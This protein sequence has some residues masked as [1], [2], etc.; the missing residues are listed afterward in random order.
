MFLTIVLSFSKSREKSICHIKSVPLT[1]RLILIVNRFF[2]PTFHHKGCAQA[3]MLGSLGLASGWHCST[4]INP[5]VVGVQ[6]GN[7]QRRSVQFVFVKIFMQFHAETKTFLARKPLVLPV[8]PQTLSAD[9]TRQD[10]TFPYF[11]PEH[12]VGLWQAAVWVCATPWNEDRRV[13]DISAPTRQCFV[14]VID[15]KFRQTVPQII[16]V[17]FKKL[18]RREH[19]S[20]RSMSAARQLWPHYCTRTSKRLTAW[21]VSHFLNA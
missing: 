10:D 12:L 3:H 7:V 19:Q 15:N 17:D 5:A 4:V 6:R 8:G 11:S 20:R 1:T 9:G 2:A 21:E 18:S 16:P 13:V 14:I